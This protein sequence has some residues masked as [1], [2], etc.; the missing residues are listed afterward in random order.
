[1]FGTVII[2]FIITALGMFVLILFDNA[3]KQTRET[4]HLRKSNERLNCQIAD[5]IHKENTRRESAAY[6]KGLYDG[7]ATDTLYRQMLKRYTTGDQ[8]TVMMYGECDG[9]IGRK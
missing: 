9:T 7:R 2:T 4:D 3:K 6:D 1:M 8:T 5:M